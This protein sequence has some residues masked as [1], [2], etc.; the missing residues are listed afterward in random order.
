M[1]C[2]SVR[3]VEKA[4]VAS[5]AEPNFNRPLKYCSHFCGSATVLAPPH[6]L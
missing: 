1:G 5:A 2:R 3:H 4:V 6:I